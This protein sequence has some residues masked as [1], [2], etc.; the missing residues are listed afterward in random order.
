M[1]SM[2]SRTDPVAAPARAQ[3][4]VWDPFVRLFHWGNLVLVASLIVSAH[5]GWQEVHMTLGVDLLILVA[6]R[7]VWGVIGPEH[8]RLRG[9]VRRPGEVLLN[10]SDILRGR[11]QRY[12]GHS[13]AGGLMVVALL[14]VLSALLITGVLLQATLEFEGPFV[15]WLSV[16]DDRFVAVVLSVHEASVEALYVLV[17][18]HLAGVALAS[19]QHRENLVAAM[20]T[21]YKSVS[22]EER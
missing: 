12:L 8:A 6:A 4:K 9:F 16:A 13:P 15:H 3:V 7:L 5:F 21:G 2:L 20:V 11:A 18:L 10:L 17:P 14:T 19:V 1:R 22:T